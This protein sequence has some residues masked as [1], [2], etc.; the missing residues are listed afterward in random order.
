MGGASAL[1]YEQMPL[2][3]FIFVGVGNNFATKWGAVAGILVGAAVVTYLTVMGLT[4]RPIFPSLGSV[5]DISVGV[6]ALLANVVVLVAVSL[7]IR[8][9]MTTDKAGASPDPALKASRRGRS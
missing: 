1:G 4:L 2:R 3:A 7:A 6:I 8:T 5:G 9:T